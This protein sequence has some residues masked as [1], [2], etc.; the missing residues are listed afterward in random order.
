MMEEDGIR[1][2]EWRTNEIEIGER[3]QGSAFEE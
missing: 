3:G 1:R 2:I